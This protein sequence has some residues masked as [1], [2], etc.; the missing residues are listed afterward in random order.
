[1]AFKTRIWVVLALGLCFDS[2]SLPL[3]RIC[4][5]G[6]SSW[7]CLDTVRVCREVSCNFRRLLD[8]L[9]WL[10]V[11]F[12]RFSAVCSVFVSEIREL[13]F[14]LR[15]WFGFNNPK[16]P[17]LVSITR[18]GLV[19]STRKGLV[20]DVLDSS[21]DP[22]S[23]ACMLERASLLAG[24]FR[25]LLALGFCYRVGGQSIRL[26]LTLTVHLQS[27]FFIF[28]CNLVSRHYVVSLG[29]THDK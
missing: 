11:C 24:V 15:G 21:L 23:Y 9:C 13:R 5:F 29:C 27:S 17:A 19:M 12:A 7:F 4:W 25:E 3:V 8:L 16:G 2:R 18:K 20:T 22:S 1:M 6:G 14:W 26:F 28:F 10:V